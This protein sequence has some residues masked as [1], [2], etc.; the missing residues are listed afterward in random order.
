MNDNLIKRQTSLSA[1]VVRF[2]RYLRTKG[3]YLSSSEE[4]DALLALSVISLNSEKQYKEILRATLAKN[5]YQFDQFH[6]L[7]YEY[8]YEMERAVDDKVKNQPSNKTKEHSSKQEAFHALK[9]WLYGIPSTE[10]MAISSYSNIEVLTKKEFPSM[11][12]EEIE[13]ILYILGKLAKRLAHRKS[14]LKKISHQKKI[15]DIRLT[16]RHNL[17]RST[18]ITDWVYSERKNKRLRLVIL[19][20]V[21][22]SMDLYSKF[23]IQM[24]YAFQNTYDKISTFAFSTALYNISEIL[25][26]HN[27]DK[28][29][30]IIADRIPQWSGGTKIGSCFHEFYSR[31]GYRKLNRKTVVMILSDGWDTGEPEVLKDAMHEI[32]K[33]ARKV[34]WLNPLAGNPKFQPSAI[35]MQNALPFIHSLAAAHNLESLKKV[36]NEL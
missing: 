31:Y 7:Y 4:S 12:E 3:Y 21:S 14:R 2:C 19:C 27:F 23:F 32:H 30:E 9:N 34:V 11:T 17:R 29:F 33:K 22:K 35:G 5:R 26:N 1:N 15:P 25:S 13:L 10:K 18:D 24:I 20:D 8:V 16:L 28:A 6:D 36:I